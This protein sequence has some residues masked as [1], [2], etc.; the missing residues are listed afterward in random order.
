M[1][2]RMP[3]A[4]DQRRA[5]LRIL[6]A[7]LLAL[8]MLG[9]G[10][11]SARAASFLVGGIVAA[12]SRPCV[13]GSA[14]GGSHPAPCADAAACCILCSADLCAGAAAQPASRADASRPPS[15]SIA[16]P[17]LPSKIDRRVAGWVTSWSAQAPPLFS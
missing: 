8:A 2:R 17:G 1:G 9:Q 11:L 6:F 12:P 16:A 4:G 10:A 3:G 5:L 7:G 13:D 15:V 14:A